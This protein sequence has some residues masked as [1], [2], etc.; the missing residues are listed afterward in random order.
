MSIKDLFHFMLVVICFQR[1]KSQFTDLA[2]NGGATITEG[3]N[4]TSGFIISPNYPGYYNY[5]NTCIWNIEAPADK[6]IRVEFIDLRLSTFLSPTAGFYALGSGSNSP[7]HK[8]TKYNSTYI[9]TINPETIAIVQRL[10]PIPQGFMIKWTFITNDPSATTPSATTTPTGVVTTPLDPYDCRSIITAGESGNFTSPNYPNNY[11]RPNNTQCVWGIVAPADKVIELRFVFYALEDCVNASHFIYYP[12]P[13]VLGPYCNVTELPS[14]LL[15]PSNQVQFHS[16]ITRSSEALPYLVEWAIIDPPT[17]STETTQYTDPPTTSPPETTQ[18]TTTG[19]PTTS[20][21]ETTQATTT[22]WSPWSDCSKPCGTG[23]RSRS[24]SCSTGNHSNCE[25]DT[26]TT[27]CNTQPC[28][29]PPT[30][31]P[32]ETTQAHTTAPTNPTT[33]NAPNVTVPVGLNCPPTSATNDSSSA[34]LCDYIQWKVDLLHDWHPAFRNSWNDNQ[35]GYLPHPSCSTLEVCC[36]N[37][38][39]RQVINIHG[40]LISYCQDGFYKTGSGLNLWKNDYTEWQQFF[41]LW[42]QALQSYSGGTC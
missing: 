8:G 18:A 37:P 40:C 19:P 26:E 9:S 24:R 17:N 41:R 32:P 20:P 38:N 15:I 33:P 28:A 23:E 35:A 11:Y 2:C 12:Q 5:I 25:A 22:E 39:Q 6:L 42:K 13:A 7:Y 34:W 27:S 30:T 29:D 31:S 1:C 10:D 21:P 16:V 4:G 14:Y 36:R 3:N